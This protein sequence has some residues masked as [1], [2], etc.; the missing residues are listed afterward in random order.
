VRTEM[1]RLPRFTA[2]HNCG[3]LRRLRVLLGDKA[4]KSRHGE[5]LCASSR[6][7]KL[8]L[9]CPQR[10]FALCKQFYQDLGFELGWSSA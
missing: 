5:Q 8:G 10:L 3:T 6:R 4:L 1:A 2:A 9:S 7:L